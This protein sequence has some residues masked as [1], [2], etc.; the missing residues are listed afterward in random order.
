MQI[1]VVEV[2]LIDLLEALERTEAPLKGAVDADQ[3]GCGA[4][5][6]TWPVHLIG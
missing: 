2:Q 6:G 5:W 3:I 4:P 1:I